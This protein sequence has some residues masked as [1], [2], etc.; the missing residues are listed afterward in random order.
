MTNWSEAIGA[1]DDAEAQIEDVQHALKSAKDLLG[2][3]DLPALQSAIDAVAHAAG[4]ISDANLDAAE[5]WDQE[6]S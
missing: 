5:R 3:V 1:L 6:E 4:C 2:D